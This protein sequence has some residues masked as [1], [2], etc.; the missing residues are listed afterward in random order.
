MKHIILSNY[1]CGTT[2]YCSNFA[3]ENKLTNMDE[4]IHE[5]YAYNQK[6]KNLSQFITSTNVIA[7]AFPYHVGHLEPAG[8][9]STCR[10]IFDEILGLSTLTVIKRR[11]VDAQIKSYAIAKL[12]GKSNKAG[13]HDEF[14]QEIT[15]HC[16]KG[17]YNQYAEFI[18][19]QNAQLEKIIRHYEHE[20]VCYEDFATEE[21]RYNRPVNL[22]ITD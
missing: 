4:F 14:D 18:V 6:V 5:Q 9:H 2:W 15:I 19:N 1:R 13:W 17:M 16:A 7:K 12:L 8:H 20:V 22:H 3:K 10:K 21:L 11:D